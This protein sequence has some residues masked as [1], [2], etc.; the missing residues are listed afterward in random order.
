MNVEHLTKLRDFLLANELNFNMGTWRS[1]A[2]VTLT[3]ER[4]LKGL[5]HNCGTAGCAIGWAPFVIPPLDKHYHNGVELIFT[6]YS[7]Y[8]CGKSTDSKLFNWCF[9]GTWDA[10]DNSRQGAAYRI[11][12]A[13]NGQIP[14]DFATA[15]R[16]C[17]PE[18]DD[19]IHL[20]DQW[21]SDNGIDFKG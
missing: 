13:L 21:F 14:E 8:V 15:Y 11:H 18:R 12:V 9:G 16:M 4:L 17:T 20:R 3:K 10:I 6:G 1:G 2:D 5:E 19:Y 7:D